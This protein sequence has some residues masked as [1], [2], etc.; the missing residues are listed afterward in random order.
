MFFYDP[1]WLLLIPALLLALWAQSRV[2]TTYA[3]YSQ[4]ASAAGVPGARVARELLDRN[5]LHEVRVEEVTG[6]L[7]DHYD[8]RSRT[9]RLS[10]DNY[11][12]PSLAALA[13]AAHECGHAVQHARS[14]APLAFRTGL[15]PVASLGSS[16][17][18][19]LIIIG[20]LFG[21]GGA[22]GSLLLMDLGIVFFAGAVLFHIVTLP[23]EFDASRRALSLLGNTGYLNQQQVGGARRVL[24]AAA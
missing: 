15:F 5:G 16:L 9:V 8:P 2:K 21:S 1:T 11:H 14:Y 23:V 3:R 13:V 19:P 20:F 24:H 22:G 10:S 7:S 6:Q 17:A 18:I 12:Q 4:V